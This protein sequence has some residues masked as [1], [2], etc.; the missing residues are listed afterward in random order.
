MGH[1]WCLCLGPGRTRRRISGALHNRPQ[2]AASHWQNYGC[3]ALE[4]IFCAAPIPTQR[5][6]DP[7]RS[8]A[9]LNYCAKRAYNAA[10]RQIAPDLLA[11]LY[12]AAIINSVISV[13]LFAGERHEKKSEGRPLC[14]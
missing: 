4:L 14:V 7:P 5:K 10:A 1:P 9:L 12:V 3:A 8:F 13:A 11:F 2:P 6:R